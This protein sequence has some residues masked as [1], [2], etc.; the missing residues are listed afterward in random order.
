[1]I[2]AALIVASGLSACAGGGSG[3]KVTAYFPSAI[4]LYEQSQ[5]RVLGLPAGHVDSIKVIG[6]KVRVVMSIP[7][8]IPLPADVNATIIPLSLVG[9][10][11]V[12]LFPAWKA[13]EERLKPNSVIP[14]ERT[15]VP[16]EPD[17]ALAAVKH[18]LDSIDPEAT[19]RLVNN[20]A[21]GLD[22]T[23]QDL[24]D[25]LNGLG[26]ITETLGDK[27]ETIASIIDHFDRITATLATR[28]QTLGRVLDAF[29]TTTDALADERV[30]IQSLLASL[31]SIATNGLDL[32]SEHHEK[33]DHDLTVLS[34]TLRLVG[35]HADQLDKTLTA[36]PLLVSGPN[37]DGKAGL[38]A[39][40]DRSLHAL[41]LR[42]SFSPDLYQVLQALGVNGVPLCL[43]I[44]VAC[45]VPVPTPAAASTPKAVSP[46]AK[47]ARSDATAPPKKRGGI[48]GVLR[49]ISSVFG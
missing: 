46:A 23:G 10:R 44:D 3:Y 19:G 7:D 36:A 12:Q 27:S 14:L 9:E 43:P 31:A 34:R 28:D 47:Q 21:A 5:I 25:A 38:V 35:S 11:Y 4:S 48:S 16:V 26:T 2:A 20:L 17:H 6:T 33:L 1:M 15:S 18:L 30:A 40:Y 32:A 37:H 24:N 8:D 42:A 22:G 13:G 41:D 49:S 29:A 39:A 45:S